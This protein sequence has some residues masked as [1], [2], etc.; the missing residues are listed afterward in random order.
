MSKSDAAQRLF[1]ALLPDADTRAALARL[2][3]LAGGR[4]VPVENLHL[5][6]AFLGRQPD[7]AVAPL[8]Q[9][10][11]RLAPA[12][13]RLHLDSLGYFSGPRIAWAGMTRP[14]AALLDLQARLQAALRQAGFAAD[15]H[16]GFR[17]HVTLARHAV[18]PAPD[19]AFA[20]LTWRVERIALMASG[21]ADGLYRT[22]AARQL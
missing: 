20:P 12:P 8:E 18:A 7:A 6:L 13:L 16:G 9:L 22:L 21:A 2:Q 17:P 19:A 15:S 14:P 5:T 3:P 1:F 11:A 4:A 10:L